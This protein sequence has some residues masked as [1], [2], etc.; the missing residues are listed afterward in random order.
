MN[1]IDLLKQSILI[2]QTYPLRSFLAILGIVI[3]IASI[4]SVVAFGEGH[5][6]QIQKEIEKIGTDIFWIEPRQIVSKNDEFNSNEL[7]PLLHYLNYT[8]RNAISNY[9]KYVNRISAFKTFFTS[10]SIDGKDTDFEI[11][12]I[13]PDYQN[14]TQIKILDGRFINYLDMELG[15]KVCV[16]EYSNYDDFKKLFT[17]DTPLGTDIFINNIKFTVIGLINKNTN[18][19]S[20][21]HNRCLYIPINL[22]EYFDPENYIDKIYCQTNRERIKTAMYCAEEIIRSRYIGQSLFEVNNAKKMFQS[23]ENLAR[24]A[25][26]VTSGIAAISL[27]VG[28]IGIMNIMLVSVSERTKEIGIRKAIGAKRKYILIQFLFESM[29]LTIC[30]GIIGTFSGIFLSKF[31]GSIISIPISISIVCIVIAV[32]FSFS[33]GVASGLYPAI[34][35]SRLNPIDSLRIE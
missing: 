24:T 32:S 8:D 17:S 6:V 13:E 18:V 1:I 19:L 31:I 23:A 4:V 21:N 26:M 30:G 33:T 14:I 15:R 25:S 28:G 12:A 7:Y 9:N 2:L 5:N 11:R 27:L 20:S 10:A 34:K 35:A 22:I 29:F 16:L 3:G